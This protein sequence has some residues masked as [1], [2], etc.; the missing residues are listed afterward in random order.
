MTIYDTAHEASIKALQAQRDD[1]KSV[2]IPQKKARVRAS[3]Q[4]KN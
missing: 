3:E 2:V 1:G 4:P